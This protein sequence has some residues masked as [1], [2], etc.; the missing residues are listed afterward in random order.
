MSIFYLQMWAAAT[1]VKRR[2]FPKEFFFG[3]ANLRS[4]LQH[5]FK[6]CYYYIIH[7]HFSSQFVIHSHNNDFSHREKRELLWLQDECM[8]AVLPCV[9]RKTNKS[10]DTTPFL[11][12]HYLTTYI[13]N[14]RSKKRELLLPLTTTN[15]ECFSK[16]LTT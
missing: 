9:Y 5:P 16:P 12:Q 2:L 14:F 1:H 4:N 11:L 10:Q 6:Q 8:E 15:N 13:L 7:A 3:K